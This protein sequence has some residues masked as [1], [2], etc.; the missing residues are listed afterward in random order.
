MSGRNVQGLLADANVS[1][2][3]DYVLRLLE[4]LGLAVIFEELALD[5]LTIDELELP[6]DIDDRS[7]WNFCQR[8]GWLLF[9][10]NRNAE[11]I[12]FASGNAR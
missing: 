4:K 7:L 2:H 5:F 9:T 10:E 3:F 11:G 6:F 8:E 1:G 12:R